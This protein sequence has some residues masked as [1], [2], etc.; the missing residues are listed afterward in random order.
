MKMN[1]SFEQPQPSYTP[2]E[3]IEDGPLEATG[4][5]GGS[6]APSATVPVAEAQP[7]PAE[8]FSARLEEE[9]RTITAQARQEAEREIQRGRAEL[10][11]AI[12]QFAQQRQKYFSQAESEVVSLTL[13][14]ARR[15]IHRETQIDPR[16]L[17][18]L[19]SYELEQL[20]AATSVRL[21]VSADSLNYWKEAATAMPHPAEVVP[22]KAL[23]AGEVRIETVLG[24][25]TVG[26]ER[27]LKEIERGFF[28][29]LSHRAAAVESRPARV[30]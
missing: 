12:E 6:A 15:L 7:D 18:G 3:Y 16:L 13:A 21:L 5:S 24:S 11:R 30:Q 22:D 1:L 17:A 23:A 27:E 10:A 2:L 28:D 9:R 8:L 20:D 4:R 25:T 26:F 29:L 14:I 19:V